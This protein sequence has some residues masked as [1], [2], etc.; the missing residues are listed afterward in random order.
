MFNSSCVGV[1]EQIKPTML[2]I[3]KSFVLSLLLLVLRL[4]LLLL[5]L[6]EEDVEDDVE[7]EDDDIFL[8]KF[9]VG[10]DGV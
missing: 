10:K 2:P 3:R 6:V 1:K 9:D 7:D 8:F 5:V 4:L